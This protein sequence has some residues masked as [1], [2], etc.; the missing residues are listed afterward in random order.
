L[1]NCIIVLFSDLEEEIDN[2]KRMIKEGDEKYLKKE[3]ECNA[4]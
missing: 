4:K 3:E 2:L 1:H